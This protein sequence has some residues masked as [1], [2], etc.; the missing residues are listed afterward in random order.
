MSSNKTLRISLKIRLALLYT[1]L[2]FI[3]CSMIFVVASLRIYREVNRMGDD[4]LLRIADNIQEIYANALNPPNREETEDTRSDYPEN[5]RR[6]LEQ[7]FPGMELLETRKQ[8]ALSAAQPRHYFTAAIFHKGNFYECRVR[9]DGT[10]YS[11]QLKN[12]ANLKQLY[13]KLHARP[14]TPEAAVN[15]ALKRH[16]NQLGRIHGQNDFFVVI[17]DKENQKNLF[18]T[19]TK[20]EKSSKVIHNAEAPR[21]GFEIAGFRCIYDELSGLGH[22]VA[23]YSIANRDAMIQQCMV[24]FFGILLVGTGIGIVVA[25]LI[26]RRFIRG[27]KQTTLAMQSISGGDYS[28]RIKIPYNDQEIVT[29]MENFNTMNERTENLLKEIRMMSDNVAHDLRTPLTRITGTVELLLSSRT[30]SPEVREVCVS[31]LEETLRL[32]ALVNTIMDISR[33]NAHPDS[34]K[35]ENVDLTA[36]VSKFCDFMLPAFE[37]QNLSLKLHLPDAPLYLEADLTMVQRMLANLIENAL[38][39]TSSGG[40]ELTLSRNSNHAVLE[41]KDSGCGISQEDLPHIFDR[42]YRA[43]ASRHLSGNGLGLPLVKAVADA[44]KWEIDV[45]STPGK[46]TIFTVT[47]PLSNQTGNIK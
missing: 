13:A 3:S 44:H 21:T 4:E 37:E 16:F 25:W 31:V 36:L 10:V 2:F 14:D 19:G 34:L 32:K 26:A 28:Y 24:I 29:L 5:E 22:L 11:K 23:G 1:L 12:I 20:F 35:K 47:M 45:K 27:I 17:R 46:G 38:K 33:T 41:I 6:I 43:D 9:Q 42:F 40:V 7:R 18:K 8:D 30:L 39:F 15:K